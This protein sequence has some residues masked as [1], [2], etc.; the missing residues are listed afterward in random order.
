MASTINRCVGVGVGVGEEVAVGVAVEAGVAAIVGV[1]VGSGVSVL[2]ATTA[3]VSG[4]WAAAGGGFGVE[5]TTWVL[6]QAARMK[7]RVKI[8]PL[9]TA[10][11]LAN[12][13]VVNL[14]IYERPL[15]VYGFVVVHSGIA[16]I[17]NN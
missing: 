16:L 12:I 2:K 5:T 7:I 4:V 11:K 3:I 9:A 8:D 13:F 1:F 17:L 14:G 10:F 15:S 6:L